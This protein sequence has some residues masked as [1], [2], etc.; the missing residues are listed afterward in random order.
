MVQRGR[1]HEIRL[2]DDEFQD[3]RADLYESCS[4]VGCVAPVFETCGCG[5]RFCRRHGELHF[6]KTHRA[7][8]GRN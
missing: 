2:R 3:S 7:S 6:K 4:E 1:F 8:A 5:R